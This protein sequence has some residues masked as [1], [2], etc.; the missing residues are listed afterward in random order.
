M[1]LHK[2]TAALLTVA[3]THIATAQSIDSSGASGAQATGTPVPATS[4][5]PATPAA[6]ASA[7]TPVGAASTDAASTAGGTVA[8]STATPQSNDPYV[9]KRIAGKEAKDEYKARKQ[10]AKAEKIAAKQEL[11]EA[12]KE[13]K[14][15]R[16]EQLRSERTTQ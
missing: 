6:P 3:F 9:Q 15:E 12:K 8:A 1:K 10:A 5:A 4:A 14:E 13:A 7:A 11:K 16:N 2:L